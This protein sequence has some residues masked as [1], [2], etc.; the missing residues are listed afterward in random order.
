MSLR[1]TK[2]SVHFFN[3]RS[4]HFSIFSLSDLLS[5]TICHCEQSGSNPKFFAHNNR[6]SA[7][8]RAII[9]FS[10]L[11]LRFSPILCLKHSVLTEPPFFIVN[12]ISTLIAFLRNAQKSLHHHITTLPHHHIITSSNHQ[13]FCLTASYKIAPQATETFRDC[14][15]PVIGNFIFSSA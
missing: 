7:A 4:T 2:Q 8:I 1:E 15:L 6:I 14:V 3:F 12:F 13:I 5:T 9:H 10:V 11:R